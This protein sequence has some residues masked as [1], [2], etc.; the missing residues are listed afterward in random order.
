MA[1]YT[2]I[3]TLY[4]RTVGYSGAYVVN[5]STIGF[6][7]S[8]ATGAW[9]IWTN[10]SKLRYSGGNTNCGVDTSCVIFANEDSDLWGTGCTVPDQDGANDWAAV[11]LVAGS[12]YNNTGD[13]QCSSV[14]SYTYPVFIVA[15]N[16]ADNW[17]FKDWNDTP[18]RKVH[19]QRHELAHGLGLWDASTVSCWTNIW[20]FVL[21]LM[22]N[23]GGTG[24]TDYPNNV[25]ASDNEISHVISKNGW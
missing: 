16:I 9:N 24:C 17:V 21:P 7:M 3:D 19:T 5:Q 8:D 4:P 23:L 11:Y 10:T 18:N 12:Y 1:D 20:G 25:S 22:R 14:G 6:S 15:I 13:S 2:V